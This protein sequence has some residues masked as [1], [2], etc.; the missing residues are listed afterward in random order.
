MNNLLSIAK[1]KFISAEDWVEVKRLIRKL[2]PYS[3]NIYRNNK[4]NEFVDNY[5]DGNIKV[6]QKD[7]YNERFGASEEIGTIII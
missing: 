5:L 6:L 1:Q 4:L 2:Q 7:H 3:I